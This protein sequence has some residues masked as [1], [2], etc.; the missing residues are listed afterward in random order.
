MFG[1]GNC[2]KSTILKAIRGD[3][4]LPEPAPTRN[5]T[6]V[7]IPEQQTIIFELGGAAGYPKM[8]LKH[9]DLYLPD[10]E[11]IIFVVDVQQPERYTEAVSY[12]AGIIDG[13]KTSEIKPKILIYLHK[14]DLN[15]PKNIDLAKLEEEMN[16]TVIKPIRAV[17][18]KDFALEFFKTSIRWTFEK[19][20]L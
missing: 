9:L 16:E 11:E 14:Y 19:K 7:E 20:Q 3:N 8:H 2:G 13:L 18:P 1:L 17:V 6:V 5:S 15:M 4:P 12:F 10:T